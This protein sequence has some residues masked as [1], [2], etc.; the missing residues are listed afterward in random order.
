MRACFSIV[1]LF[2][3]LTPIQAHR[4]VSLSPV[5]TEIVGAVS[6][7]AQLIGVTDLC[8]FPETVT[9]LPKI[10]GYPPS[11]EAIIAL[12]PSLVLG[13]DAQLALENR[14][15]ALGIQTRFYTSPRSLA[16]VLQLIEDVGADV[17]QIQASQKLVTVL[18]R[19]IASVSPN[20]ASALVVVQASPLIV[21]GAGTYIA[22]MVRVSG[23][24]YG[25]EIKP[26]QYPRLG[27]EQ[28]IALDLD[29]L[30]FM[31]PASRL[32][33]LRQPTIR[34]YIKTQSIEMHVIPDPDWIARAGPRV[35]NGIQAMRQWFLGEGN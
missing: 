28:L 7:D 30:I 5:I 27:L 14:L 18:K 2:F 32:D 31:S 1:I 15:Q 23:A 20:A 8:T 34:R 33:F 25:I 21:A 6:G 9:T 4:I 3:V 19:Q 16:G 26:T 10:G 11:L 24:S 13:L 29:H 17:G 22:D 12:N 35:V